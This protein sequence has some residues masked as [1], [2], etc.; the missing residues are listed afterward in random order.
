VDIFDGEGGWKPAKE[1]VGVMMK[2]VGQNDLVAKYRLWTASEGDG[3]RQ[4][5]IG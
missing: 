3:W 5:G 4:N 1:A 2:L